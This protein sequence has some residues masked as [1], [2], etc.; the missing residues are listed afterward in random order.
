MKEPAGGI[1]RV[2]PGSGG[3]KDEEAVEDGREPPEMIPDSC[4]HKHTVLT[5]ANGINLDIDEI[6]IVIWVLFS[7][8][9][10]D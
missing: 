4:D 3:C 2:D 8:Q 1:E 9:Y 7:I 6:R 10:N 5:C